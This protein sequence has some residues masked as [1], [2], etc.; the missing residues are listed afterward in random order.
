M[1]QHTCAALHTLCQVP[2]IHVEVHVKYFLGT[3]QIY[4]SGV[5]RMGGKDNDGGRVGMQR[6]SSHLNR[7]VNFLSFALSPLS[8]P[9]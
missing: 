5:I 4:G 6:S 2:S 3:K 9:L 7:F 8:P 1:L